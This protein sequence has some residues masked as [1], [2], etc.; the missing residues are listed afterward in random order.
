MGVEGGFCLFRFKPQLSKAEIMLGI[1]KCFFIC[2]KGE[3]YLGLLSDLKSN[4]SGTSFGWFTNDKLKFN[5]TFAENGSL[6]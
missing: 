1:K 5:V 4:I 2:S 3:S 6:Y